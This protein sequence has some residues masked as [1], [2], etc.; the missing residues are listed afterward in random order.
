MFIATLVL[1]ALL[2]VVFVAA[3]TPKVLQKP[4]MVEAAESHGFTKD[5]Y[6]IIGLLEY[7]GAAGLLVG[8]WFAPL[9]IAAG[10]GLFLLMAGAVIVH[11]R[12]KDKAAMTVPSAVLALLVAAALVLRILTA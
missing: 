3:G 4:V 1:S 11:V 2:A 10:I 6:R 9:G 5:S 8:L 12:F 7:A